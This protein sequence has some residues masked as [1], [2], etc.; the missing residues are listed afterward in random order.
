MS[1]VQGIRQ[2]QG[3]EREDS[4]GINLLCRRAESIDI[5]AAGK[6]A[7]SLRAGGARGWTGTFPVWRFHSPEPQH[8][9]YTVSVPSG[10]STETQ[11][12]LRCV[13]PEP[14]TWP[15]LLTKVSNCKSGC[16]V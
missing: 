5:V 4:R 12:V 6:L 15:K 14:D 11:E 16:A 2:P 9:A 1:A 7:P 13:V 10:A 8:K 3:T